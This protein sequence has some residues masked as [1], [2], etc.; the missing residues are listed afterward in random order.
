MES[1][2]L[3]KAISVLSVIMI[4]TMPFGIATMVDADTNDDPLIDSDGVR[5]GIPRS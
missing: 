3:K 2:L 4:M 5:S 1:G